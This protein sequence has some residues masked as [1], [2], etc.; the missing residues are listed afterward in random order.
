MKT[1]M[2]KRVLSVLVA[3]V[4]VLGLMPTANIANAEGSGNRA[5]QLGVS[6]IKNPETTST[7]DY[8][9]NSYIYFGQYQGS[10]VKWRVLDADIANDGSTHGR[11]FVL[12]DEAIEKTRFDEDGYG[13]TY[14]GSNAQE[15]CTNFKKNNFTSAEQSAM[16][17]VAKTDSENS[18][19]VDPI[20]KF[21]NDNGVSGTY[22]WGASKLTT[23]DKLFFLSAEELRNYVGNYTG[24]GEETSGGWWLRSPYTYVD[25]SGGKYAGVV[26][27]GNKVAVSSTINRISARP[28]MNLDKDSV[29]FIS[30]AQGGKTAAGMSSGLTSVSNYDGKEWKLTLKDTSRTLKVQESQATA[31]AG[32]TVKLNFSGATYTSGSTNEYISAILVNNDSEVLYYGRVQKLTSETGEVSITIPEG[33][34]AGSY[35]LK[36]FNEQF[37]GDYKTDYASEFKDVNLTVKVPVQAKIGANEY[38]T[39]T[40][41][42]TAAGANQTADT[43]EIV[44]NTVTLSNGTGTLPKNDSIK[45][46]AGVGND[47]TIKFNGEIKATTDNVTLGLYSEDSSGSTVKFTG[48]AV[49]LVSGRCLLGGDASATGKSGVKITNLAKDDNDENVIAVIADLYEE[50]NYDIVILQGGG[51]VKI[52]NVEYENADASKGM[53]IQ[54]ASDGSCTLLGGL[55]KLDNGEKITGYS[56]AL[57]KN[58]GN[59]EITV[60]ADN[61]D[62]SDCVIVPSGGKATIGSVEYEAGD[63]E[64]TFKIAQNGNVTLTDGSVKLDKGET[65]IVDDGVVPVINQNDEIITATANSDGTGSVLIP[66]GGK[67]KFNNNTEITAVD[68]SASV[69]IG[70]DGG[71]TLVLNPGKV[72]IGDITYTDDVLL[73]IDKDGKVTVDKGNVI[74]DEKA[75]ADPDFTYALLSGQSATIGKYTYTA[76]AASH[77]GDVTI[78]SQGEGNNP[79]VVLKSANTAVDVSLASDGETKTTYT[80]VNAYTTFAMSADDANTKN[81]DLLSNGNTA[82]NSKVKVRSGV[83]V[84]PK[85]SSALTSTA[86]DTVIGLDSSLCGVLESGAAKTSGVMDVDW[87][88]YTWRFASEGNKYTVDTVNATITLNENG[89]V[90]LEDKISFTGKTGDIFTM[91][92]SNE[93]LTAIVPANAAV[94]GNGSTIKG[95]A[96]TEGSKDTKIEINM[97][98]GELTLIEGAGIV[99]IANVGEEFTMGGQTYV[100]AAANTTFYVDNEGNVK[101]ISGA[102]ELDDDESIIGVKGK[103]ITN[104][105]ESGEDK[106]IVAVEDGKDVVTI[107]TKGGKVKIGDIEYLAAADNTKIVVDDNGNK[108]I[109]GAVELADGESIIGVKGKLITNPAESGEDKLIVA[110]EDGKDVVT[111]PTKGGKV[112]IGDI[113]YLAAAD[114]TKIVVDDNGNKLISG[115]VEL[116]DGESIIG[117]NGKLIKNPAYS[118]N[119]K[120]IITVDGDKDIVEVPA[121]GQIEIGGV[122]YTAGANGVTLEV[123]SDGK[124]SISAGSLKSISSKKVISTKTNAAKTGDNSNLALWIALLFISCATVI[125]TTVVSRKKKYNKN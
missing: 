110:V 45:T 94:T 116:A 20:N 12:S 56:K 63:K 8:T 42:L 79:A 87:G 84:K 50:E 34:D 93:N 76:P 124:V 68:G 119:D 52:G 6:A 38:T 86:V 46:F 64:A 90:T 2:E 16:K 30:A 100:T 13:N 59:K 29:L 55:V 43:I 36:V 98:T 101:L 71:L 28:A 39:L 58:S 49:N 72:K 107:P 120:L 17:G 51:K 109:S 27:G 106:L 61:S 67:A 104:P 115:A 37:N 82:V 66:Q 24:T 95:V 3:L 69:G 88:E 7:G 32:G 31:E 114:N 75:L 77:P 113:E 41:A 81:I 47:G 78:K 35:T 91:A 54:V 80:A 15:W 14:Q 18:E 23:D 21:L 4:M 57:I 10:A 125:G 102:V 108:L 25:S 112:K 19:Y 118:G 1:S 65:I 5:I 89:A 97:E 92:K 26:V 22:K 105:A 111:I 33:L 40:A 96:K 121:N 60:G 11:M 83:T 73:N 48:G 122:L 117:A 70:T 62:W 74:I 53:Q 9:P 103:L 44:K 123:A 99:T 85:N